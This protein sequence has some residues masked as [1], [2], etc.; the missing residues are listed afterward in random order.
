MISIVASTE[1]DIECPKDHVCI[2][3]KVDRE[4][5]TRISKALADLEAYSIACPKGPRKCGNAFR[6]FGF[7][8]AAPIMAGFNLVDSEDSAITG[9]GVACGYTRN[10]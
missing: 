9:L 2:A 8:C 7:G 1:P 6:R 5:Q 10:I 3:K 4:R